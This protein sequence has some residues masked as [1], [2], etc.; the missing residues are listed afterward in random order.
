MENLDIK[1]LKCAM[2]HQDIQPNAIGWREGHNGEP[3]V[4]GRVCDA[5]NVSV[6]EHRLGVLKKAEALKK[7]KA[8]VKALKKVKADVSILNY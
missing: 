8:K 7:V 3:L 2:C 1:F 4:D 5:C 6:V